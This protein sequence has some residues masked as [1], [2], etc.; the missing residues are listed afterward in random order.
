MAKQDRPGLLHLPPKLSRSSCRNRVVDPFGFHCTRAL[1]AA[2]PAQRVVR[3]RYCPSAIRR[4]AL[5]YDGCKVACFTLSPRIDPMTT[6][7]ESKRFVSRAFVVITGI[8]LAACGGGGGDSGALASAQST[9]VA[10][11]ITPVVSASPVASD[12]SL[13]AMEL[14]LTASMAGTGEPQS[15]AAAQ[16]TSSS[17]SGINGNTTAQTETMSVALK[18]ATSSSPTVNAAAGRAFYV[19]S[20]SGNDTADGLSPSVGTTGRGPWRSLA[21]LSSAGLQPGDAVYLACGST[22]SETLKLNASGTSGSPITVAAYPAA[23]ATPPVIDGGTQIAASAWALH[24]NNIYKTTLP[25]AP[26]Q[27]IPS[28]GYM[29]VA[30]HPNRGFDNTNPAS[31]YLK[32]AVDSDKVA[33][34]GRTAS[35]YLTTGP[36]LVLPAG[37]SIPVG[38][39]LRMRTNSWVVDESKVSAV[40]GNKLSLTVPTSYPLTAGWGYFLT[41]QLWMLDSPGEWHYDATSHQLY[42]WMPNSSAP[43]NQVTVAQLDTA[44]DLAS[45]KY[46]N[47]DGLTVRSV[48]KGFNLRSATA[49]TLSNSRIENTAGIGIDGA[50]STGVMINA[51]TILRTGADAVSGQDNLLVAATAMQVSGNTVTDSGVAMSGE[52]VLSLPQ[53]SYGAIR[54]GNQAVVS[55][56][57]IINA[58]YIGIVAGQGNTISDNAIFGACSVIDDGAGIYAS[59]FGNNSVI[60]ANL[61]QHSRGDSSGKS[62]A[63]AYTQ[64]QGIYLDE[65]ASGVTVT[66]NTAIDADNGLHIHVS[67]N[68]TI[69]QNKFYGNRVSQIWMQETRNTTNPLG[70]LYGNLV[71]SNQ[72]VPTLANS[73]GIY[74]DTLITDTTRFGS[75]NF[76]RYLDRVMTT[77]GDERS[78]TT[79]RSYNLAQWKAATTAAGASRQFDPS[80]SG[81]SE[82]QYAATLV[83]GPSIVPNGSLATSAAG[84]TTWNLTKPYGS[85]VRE[86]C[87]AGWCAR[88]ITGASPGLLTSAFFSIVAGTWYRLSV[89]I[90]T[91][92]DGQTVDLVVRR[93]GGGTNGYESLSDRSLKT[94]AGRTWTRYNYLFKATK[95][96]KAADP[97]TGDLGARVDFQGIQPGQVLSVANL[98]LVPTTAAD[99]VTRSDILVNNGSTSIQL[100]CPASAALAGLCSNYVRLS[101]DLPVAWPIT[102]APRATEI[103]YTRDARLVDSDGDGVA[104]SQDACPLT[105]IRFGVD[106]RGC[107]L[108][109]R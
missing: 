84:W 109:Q 72:I 14:A 5:Q 46:I 42:V 92:T 36:D 90:A 30:H 58:A 16:P 19:S 103:V 53:R 35:T 40:N 101:N 48:G 3:R 2:Y 70:D 9:P 43:G 82:T 106:A 62:A 95:T 99:A 104:D 29:T 21:K 54:A 63:F 34:G 96:I 10:A 6:L 64:A 7:L 13:T 33:T 65:S 11:A 41:G 81:V 15:I 12:S 83:T 66:G 67:A 52:T 4:R 8:A 55:G 56:N 44:V 77:V 51:N 18:V 69:R 26:L 91:G 31:L 60:S 25:A 102:L 28:S 74:L 59:G 24:Q 22:W 76:N 73:K 27:L 23:C 32:I 61:I 75:F 17:E 78:P 57:A 100:P 85:M 68:N 1:I 71:E 39:T 93:G 37:A 89:D 47:I 50:G 107:A 20:V 98:E 108:A 94:T 79:R 97:I 86:A 105:P 45:L 80:G 87:P 88:Y 49:I 38:T